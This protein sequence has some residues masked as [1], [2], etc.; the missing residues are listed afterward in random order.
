MEIFRSDAEA[1]ACD[2]DVPR[3]N[4]MKEAVTFAQDFF[5]AHVLQTHAIQEALFSEKYSAAAIGLLQDA[6]GPCHERD[7]TSERAL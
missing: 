3:L 2:T 5:Q 1:L 7:L 4:E 6:G